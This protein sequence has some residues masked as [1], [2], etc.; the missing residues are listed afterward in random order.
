MRDTHRERNQRRRGKQASCK[1]PDAGLDP[2][3][4]GSRPEPQADAQPLTRPGGPKVTNPDECSMRARR[5][6]VLCCCC[7]Q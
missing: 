4:L 7:T 3:T 5:D 6:C 1:E 2:T